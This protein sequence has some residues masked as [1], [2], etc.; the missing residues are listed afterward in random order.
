MGNSYVSKHE[1]IHAVASSLEIGERGDNKDEAKGLNGEKER[2]HLDVALEL[3]R[4]REREELEAILADLRV[5]GEKAYHWEPD[6]PHAHLANVL[7]VEHAE[8]EDELEED[9]VPEL[10]FY[11]LIYKEKHIKI[12]SRLKF[13]ISKF[14]KLKF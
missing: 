3:R 11:V 12:M 2:E 13:L 9:E 4:G 6:A 1:K 14:W 10:I 8:D 5:D 7:Q